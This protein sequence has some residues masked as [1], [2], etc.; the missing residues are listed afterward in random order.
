[1]VGS[2]N[3]TCPVPAAIKNSQAL[4]DSN[5]NTPASAPNGII[6]SISNGKPS[7]L[8]TYTVP[9]EKKVSS[10]REAAMGALISTVGGVVGASVGKYI[11]S[12]LPDNTR[13]SSIVGGIVGGAIGASL[14]PGNVYEVFDIS[15]D[16]ALVSSICALTA[17]AVLTLG[18]PQQVQNLI[19]NVMNNALDPAAFQ[20]VAMQ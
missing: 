19:P 11:A 12:Q 9:T 7:E 13:G 18:R 4:K 20:A 2:I 17:G 16:A 14:I 5:P 3:N 8:L 6:T 15:A 10:M 1:M